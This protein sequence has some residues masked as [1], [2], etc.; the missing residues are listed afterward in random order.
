MRSGSASKTVSW[1][2][3]S[4]GNLPIGEITSPLGCQASA[5]EKETMYRKALHITLL[6]AS[7]LAA[8]AETPVESAMEARF[9]IDLKVPDAAL[10]AMLPK[11]FTLNVAPQGPAKD[12]NLR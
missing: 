7:V 8:R 6:A 2:H 5:K 11:G 1:S 12:C 10:S 4:A 3:S 9:Q